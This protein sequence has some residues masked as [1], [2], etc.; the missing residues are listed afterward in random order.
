MGRSLFG[1]NLG[2]NIFWRTSGGKRFF[3]IMA[4]SQFA[5]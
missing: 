5:F 4:V 3:M 2:D 1:C